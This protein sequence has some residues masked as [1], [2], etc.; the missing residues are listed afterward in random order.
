MDDCCIWPYDN[1]YK[2]PIENIESQ[3]MNALKNPKGLTL[4]G[5]YPKL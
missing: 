5:D 1:S 4:I 2:F 3:L